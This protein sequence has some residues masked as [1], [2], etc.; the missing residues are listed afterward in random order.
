M[1]TNTPS[2]GDLIDMLMA[3]NVVRMC[4]QIDGGLPA[5]IQ[6]RMYFNIALDFAIGLVPFIGDVA[7]A[8]FRANTRNAWILEEYLVK[9]AEADR[10]IKA[11]QSPVSAAEGHGGHSN[12]PSRPGATHAASNG[13]RGLFG[14]AKARQDDEEMAVSPAGRNSRH[15]GQQ[16]GVI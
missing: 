2:I 9:K 7:D 3:W 8:I 16:E 14:G 6:S 13:L 1:L 11:G 12:L 15:Q 4:G 5:A 10:K